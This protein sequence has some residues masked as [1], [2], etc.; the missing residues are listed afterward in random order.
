VR[1]AFPLSA[2]VSPLPDADIA[3]TMERLPYLNGVIN[4]TLRLFPTVPV[5]IRVSRVD[6]HLCDHPIPKGTEILISPWLINRSKELWGA[7]AE[8]FRPERWIDD[9]RPN[10]MGG[11]TSNYDYMTF[12]HGPRSCIGQNFA[13]A[14]LR[15][16]VAAMVRKFE[17]ELNMDEKDI[18]P[19]GAITIK[20]TKGLHVKV[21]LAPE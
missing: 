18:I 21:K 17:W 2:D 15:C 13:K 16:L 6:T 4:E 7:D 5:T 3:G 19:G 12:L 20:P 11:A 8:V 14:E 10:N 9:G 1:E